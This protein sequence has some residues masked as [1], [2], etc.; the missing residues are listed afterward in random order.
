MATKNG[1]DQKFGNGKICKDC[2]FGEIFFVATRKN[3]N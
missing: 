2:N 3:G 1:H